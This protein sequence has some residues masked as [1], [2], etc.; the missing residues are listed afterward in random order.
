MAIAGKGYGWEPLGQM[1]G[2]PCK[3]ETGRS[4]PGITRSRLGAVLVLWPIHIPVLPMLQFQKPCQGTITAST[5][6]SFHRICICMPISL[7]RSSVPEA[8]GERVGLES[9]WSKQHI[10]LIGSTSL[11]L[12][13]AASENLMKTVELGIVAQ[14]CNLL[15]S[16]HWRGEYGRTERLNLTWVTK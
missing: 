8:H 13:L 16:Q 2:S 15:W 14:A 1:S 10:L 4:Y 5:V 9:C 11:F 6:V 3:W 12:G 7:C